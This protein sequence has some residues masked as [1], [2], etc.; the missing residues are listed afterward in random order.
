[1]S[2]LHLVYQNNIIESLQV[3]GDYNFQKQAL[4]NPTGPYIWIFYEDY[5]NIFEDNTLL[6]H[7]ENK[8]IMFSQE[9]DRALLDLAI[10]MKQV[11]KEQRSKDI[12]DHILVDMPEMDMVRQKANCALK[13]VKEA[14]AAAKAEGET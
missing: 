2:N 1:M 7:W 14:V 4:L 11:L 13:L 3:A 12:P 9:A 10:I 5:E 8:N 6:Y